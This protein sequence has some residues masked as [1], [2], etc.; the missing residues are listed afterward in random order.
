MCVLPARDVM[1]QELQVEPRIGDGKGG[2]RK[3]RAQGKIPGILYGHKEKA[4]SFAVRP[5]AF[6]RHIRGSGYGRNTVLRV[7]GLER[8]AIALLKDTQVDPV[9]RDLLHI[10][11]I[12]VRESEEVTVDVPVSYSGRAAGVVEGGLL[13]IVRRRV[14]V[15]CTPLSIPKVIDIDVTDMIIGRT[16]H[17]T[18]VTFPEGTRAGCSGSLT[19]VSVAAPPAVAETAETEES[20]EGVT[21]AAEPAEGSA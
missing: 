9:R 1:E 17:V 8:D 16:L 5:D 20:E 19:M 18:D 6:E 4:L 10:D 21:A 2:A 12:E 15:V 7:R 11:L 14:P 3:L 13:Q